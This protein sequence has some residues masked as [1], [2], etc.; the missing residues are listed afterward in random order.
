MSTPFWL[1]RAEAEALH[2]GVIKIGGG[3]AGIRDVALL[4]SALARPQN[5]YTYGETDLFQ[6]AAS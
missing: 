5:H 2:E 4:D 3:A 6:L 1:S